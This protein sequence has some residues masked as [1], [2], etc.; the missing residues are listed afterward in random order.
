[1]S[2]VTF[3]IGLVVGWLACK[4]LAG[5]SQ[6][7]ATPALPANAAPA[8]TAPPIAAATPAPASAAAPESSAPV[9]AAA[10]TSTDHAGLAAQLHSAKAEIESRANEVR[11]L[12]TELDAARRNLLAARHTA[13][14]HG[15]TIAS[16]R[17]QVKR[18]QAELKAA[19][20]AASA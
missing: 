6:A 5:S 18:L 12:E 19:L 2:V 9:A 8:A 17:D 16:L 10:S 11:R 14:N 4:L 3:L 1:V 7:A 20:Q 15:S 13:S